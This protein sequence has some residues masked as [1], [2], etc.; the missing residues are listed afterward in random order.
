M[1][2]RNKNNPVCECTHV[3]GS[4]VPPGEGPCSVCDCQQARIISPRAQGLAEY[5]RTHNEWGELR[6]VRD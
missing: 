6:A 2:S 1:A 4:H 5:A 3:P